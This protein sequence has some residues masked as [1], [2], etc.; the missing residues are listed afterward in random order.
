MESGWDIAALMAEF[1]RKGKPSGRHGVLRPKK[2]NGRCGIATPL[3]E[4]KD[5]ALLRRPEVA[6][7]LR[8]LGGGP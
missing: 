7:W 3:A 2:K 6:G 5:A 8:M 4:K 1:R